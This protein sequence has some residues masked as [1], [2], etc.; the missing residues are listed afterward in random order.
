MYENMAF[1]LASRQPL[2]ITAAEAAN[3]IELANAVLL[4]STS[5]KRM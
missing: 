5:G 4:S 1:T 2:L 3:T